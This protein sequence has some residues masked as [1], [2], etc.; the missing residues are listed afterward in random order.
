MSKARLLW[1]AFA[2]ATLAVLVAGIARADTYDKRT[3]FTFN[4]PISLPGVTLPAGE[5]LF[6]IVDT[7]T[8]RKVIQVLSGDGKTP[9]AMLHSIPEVRRDASEKPEVRFL[10]TAKGQPSAVKTW[11][12]PGERIGYEFIYPKHQAQELAK[13][14]AEPVLTT[15]VETQKPQEAELE[16][17]TPSGE[18]TPVVIVPEPEPIVPTGIAQEGTVAEARTALP[19]TATRVP[20]VGFIGLLALVFAGALRVFRTERT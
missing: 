15:K 12:Y 13:V 2:F 18:E 3:V 19:V 14:V 5:Y 4:R 6:R 17:I 1:R 16:R 20:L 7:E 9:Y 11:W 8:N 10:E